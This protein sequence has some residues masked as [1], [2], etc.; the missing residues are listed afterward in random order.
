VGGS[1]CKG[2]VGKTIEKIASKKQSFVNASLI[3]KISK[4]NT[5]PFLI[6]FEIFIIVGWIQEPLQM[7]LPLNCVKNAMSNLRN[8][9]SKL[10]SYMNQVS[11]S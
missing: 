4:Y 1:K 10:Y 3:G 2:K 5:P 11:R 9:T 6:T 8:M 7:L